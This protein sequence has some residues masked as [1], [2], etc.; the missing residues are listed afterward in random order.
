MLK[1]AHL[2][3]EGRVQGVGFR[4]TC[5]DIARD[6]DIRGWVRNLRDGRVELL[7]QA[8]EDNLNKFLKDLSAAFVGYIHSTDIQWQE[9]E[10]LIEDFKVTF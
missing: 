9:A 8:E 10:P 7:A 3:Y 2:Y 4:Y 6:L 5:V 1:Q